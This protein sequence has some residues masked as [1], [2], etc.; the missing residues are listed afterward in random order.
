MPIGAWAP[1]LLTGG[2]F[3]ALAAGSTNYYNKTVKT[4]PA[5]VEFPWVAGFG[6]LLLGIIGGL[7]TP[8][9]ALF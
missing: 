5:W 7:S 8:V 6:L 3:L 4:A 9:A 2:L 1:F